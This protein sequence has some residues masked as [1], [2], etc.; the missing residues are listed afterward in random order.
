M[1]RYRRYPL[2][3]TFSLFTVLV[4]FSACTGAPGPS[5]VPPGSDAAGEYTLE[6]KTFG[7]KE[8]EVF[9]ED[10]AGP[11]V[12]GDSVTFAPHVARLAAGNRTHDIRLDV[13]TREIEIAQGVRY[14]AWTFGGTVPGPVIHVREGDRINFVMK[15][16][17]DEAVSVT[18]PERDG[19]PFFSQLA[20]ANLQKG[21]SQPSPMQHSMDFHAGTVAADDKWRPIQPGQ[22]LRFTWV[23]NYPGVYIYHCGVPP[24]LQHVAMGQYG[25]VIVSPRNGYDTDRQVA[26]EYAVVQSEFYLKPAEVEP[27]ADGNVPYVFDMA[28]AMAKQP[29]HVLFNGHAQALTSPTLTANAGERVRL[30]VHNVGPN[31]QSSFHVIGAI[32]DKIFYEGN[33]ANAWRGMQTVLLGASN[34]AV[35]EFIVPE[36]GN[37]VLVDHE[38]ADVQR[39][40]VG[41][42]KALSRAGTSLRKPVTGGGH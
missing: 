31:D 3:P 2:L 30:Y 21:V 23:A 1:I 41:M 35:V 19:A 16:R 20:A 42:L 11:P 28:A 24:V 6:G 33:P 8:A 18:A 15:N 34:G 14:Q 10:Y 12:V 37:Y 25:I 4:G 27:D 36:E 17:T 29:S 32:F 26:R 5:V 40:A 22:S 39:G 13:L 7:M 9:T 38:F